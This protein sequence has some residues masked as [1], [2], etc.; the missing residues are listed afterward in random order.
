MSGAGGVDTGVLRG[1]GTAWSKVRR[2]SPGSGAN[3]LYGV[4]AVSRSDAWAVGSYS[5]SLNP[6]AYDTLILHWNGTAWT[7]VKSPPPS[8]P[9][10][11]F[12][13]VTA[14]P[15]TAACPPGYYTHATA[16]AS[17]PPT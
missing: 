7:Q 11:S 10:N 9:C 14:R 1:K 5:S 4:S 3:Y 15:G 12:E 2:P 17:T 6:G 13:G 8:S 16:A